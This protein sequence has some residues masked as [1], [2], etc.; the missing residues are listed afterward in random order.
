MYEGA[1]I[2]ETLTDELILD[3]LKIDKVEIWKTN[4][5]IKYWTMVFFKS[6]ESDFP[7]KL[8]KAL[9]DGWFAD[10]KCDNT[11]S[12][13]FKNKVLKYEIGN[14]VEKEAVLKECRSMGI[15]DEQFNW[16]E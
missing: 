12:I 3:C 13:V 6:N 5:T 14:A 1:I 4:E 2:K 7:E 15:P 10:M 11:K 9:I 16:S 8:S